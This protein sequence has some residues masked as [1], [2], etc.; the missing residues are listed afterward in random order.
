MKTN[1]TKVMFFMQ[2][3]PGVVA[4]PRGSKTIFFYF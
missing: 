3:P 2:K 1:G 4:T